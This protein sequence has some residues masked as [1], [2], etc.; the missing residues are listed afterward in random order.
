MIQFYGADICKDCRTAHRLLTVKQ[1]ETEFIDITASTANLRAFLHLR[2]TRPEFDEV[3]KEGRIGI[4]AFVMEDGTVVLGN[5]WI[6]G[7]GPGK[8]C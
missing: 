8:S 4:P 2:D 5:D 3:K 1:M 7:D 6:R